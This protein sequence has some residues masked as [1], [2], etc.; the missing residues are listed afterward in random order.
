MYD[1]HE[2]IVHAGVNVQGSWH[3]ARL[4]NW[5]SLTCQK[6][7]DDMTPPGF[8]SF[9]DSAFKLHV[10]KTIGKAVRACKTNKT[11]NITEIFELQAVDLEHQ[12]VYPSENQSAE[13]GVQALKVPS[14]KPKLPLTSDRNIQN[15]LFVVCNHLLILRARKSDL[16]HI[17]TTLGTVRYE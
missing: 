12:R 14:E 16:N 7:S 13:W 15:R 10:K 1:F 8:A 2:A 4:L 6:L 9:C 11:A 5:S 17:C 3:N